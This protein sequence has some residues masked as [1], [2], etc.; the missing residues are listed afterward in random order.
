MDEAENVC[1]AS[2]AT[3]S[4]ALQTLIPC[5]RAAAPLARSHPDCEEKRD[6]RDR[7]GRRPNQLDPHARLE[8]RTLGLFPIV[9]IGRA[10]EKLCNSKAEGIIGVGSAGGPDD[11]TRVSI[12]I[13]RTARSGWAQPSVSTAGPVSERDL[14]TALQREDLAS[15]VRRGDLQAQT[16]EDTADHRHLGGV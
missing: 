11:W 1:C 6:P 16:F 2:S 10:A 12:L 4:E 9:D 13:L 14:I 15:L 5:M 8:K 3:N 7:S